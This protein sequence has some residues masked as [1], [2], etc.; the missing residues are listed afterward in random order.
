MLRRLSPL[1]RR[2]VTTMSRKPPAEPLVVVLGSTGTGKSDLAV[3]LAT[4]LNGEIINADAMQ[5]YN[6]LPIITNKITV[7]EQRGIPHHL[8]GHISL[9]EQPWDVDDFKREATRT[10]REIRGRGRLPIL[11]GGS[12]YYVDPI[13]FKEVIL[14]DIDLDM[15]K[16]FP[17][18]QES[19]EVMLHELR[20]V[21]PVM[22]DRWHPKDRRKIQRSLEIY[23]RSGKRASEYY[24]E[25]QARKEAAQQDAN[26]QPWENLLFWVYSERDVLRDRLDKRVDKMQ[27]NGLMDEVRELYEFKH[28]KE[29]EGQRLDMTKGIW[30]SIGYKQFEPY[31]SA[32]DEGREAA[33]LEKLKSAGLEEMKSATRRYAVYQTRWIRLKQIPR[34]RE[35]GPEAM[36]NMYLLDSTDVSE[37]GQNV[38]EPAIELTEQFLKGEERPLPTEISS[39]AKEVLTQVGNP[40][41]KATPCKRTC[42]V[43]HTVLMTE[44]AWKQHL[45]SSTHRRVVRKKARTSLVPVEKVPKDKDEEDSGPELGSMFSE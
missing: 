15:S 11:V 38:V 43:C 12:Q 27:T 36:N 3:E 44:E 24:A 28:K 41:P 2:N 26:K 29:V 23:L 21:D 1:L 17:I 4:R 5:L 40:P 9:D 10:I 8:L 6:G 25:Q 35:I 16:S 30:Q 34:I 22:A 32:V 20:K 14:D 31:L 7:E 45:K 33:E 18:L 42:E 13:L 37:Y 39:L 19:G